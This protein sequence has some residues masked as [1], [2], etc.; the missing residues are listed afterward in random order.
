MPRPLEPP[1]HAKL[2][3]KAASYLRRNHAI[4]ITEIS[5]GMETPDAIGF[6]GG[7][8][9]TLIECKVSR[10]DYLSGLQKFFRK[11]QE[12][13]MGNYRYYLTPKGMIA[14][15]ELP[16]GWGLLELWGSRVHVIMRPTFKSERNAQGERAIL[17]SLIRR[18]GQDSPKGVSI[19]F[20][21]FQ[22]KNTATA[23]VKK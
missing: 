9:T 1:T 4:V 10:G 19:K 17:I 2:T 7:G 12:S 8:V 21:T 5:G 22:T 14:L 20:Y 13:G 11:R 15:A 16:P 3:E 23:G 18:I 6:Q